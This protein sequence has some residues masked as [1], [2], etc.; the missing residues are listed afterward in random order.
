MGK[1]WAFE[2]LRKPDAEKG[3][4]ANGDIRISG[5]IAVNLEGKHNRGNNVNETDIILRIAVDIVYGRRQQ[6]GNHKFLK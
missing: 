2:I 3:G 4:A 1:I 5:K 6:T